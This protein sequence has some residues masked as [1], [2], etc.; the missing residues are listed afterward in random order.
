VPNW[1]NDM[2]EFAVYSNNKEELYIYQQLLKNE[3][4][5]HERSLT[6]KSQ[7]PLKNSLISSNCKIIRLRCANMEPDKRDTEPA[8][9]NQVAPPRYGTRFNPIS[10]NLCLEIIHAQN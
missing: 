5:R 2:D 1:T 4:H 10:G 8:M 3:N 9:A 6:K 7:S